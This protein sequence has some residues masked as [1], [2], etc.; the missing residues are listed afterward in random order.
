[1]IEIALFVIVVGAVS[2]AA[3]I[4]IALV[5]GWLRKLGRDG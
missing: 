2:I 3:G 4:N 5:V 1:V